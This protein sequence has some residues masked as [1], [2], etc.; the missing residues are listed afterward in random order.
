MSGS[1]Q[2]PALDRLQ[3]SGGPLPRP[4]AMRY[5]ITP[6]TN[7]VELVRRACDRSV[8]GVVF[9]VAGEHGLWVADLGTRGSSIHDTRDAAVR[10]VEAHADA[11]P[12][13]RIA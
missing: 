9:R 4:D 11:D 5:V 10:A 3:R 12:A 7:G 6:G 13:S 8:V 1:Q 2:A